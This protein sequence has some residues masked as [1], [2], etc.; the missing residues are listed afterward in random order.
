MKKRIP[1]LVDQVEFAATSNK[2]IPFVICADVSS[3]MA[4]CAQD[5]DGESIPKIEGLRRGVQDGVAYL[6]SMPD[7]RNAVRLGFCTFGGKVTWTPFAALD[8][9]VVP[10]FQA[11][12]YTPMKEALRTVGDE[13]LDF[14]MDMNAIGRPISTATILVVSDGA[15]TTGNPTA[16]IE[17]LLEWSRRKKVHLIAGGVVE[18]DRQN[19]EQLGFPLTA[20]VAALSWKGLIDAGTVS[21]ISIAAG[22]R[23]VSINLCGAPQP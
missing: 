9:V 18:A 3:S 10:D 23:P 22:Q 21:V 4:A 11:T 19:L 14:A 16:E 20:S 2:I 17:R 5:G 1:S 15:P 12:G 7:L 13:F 6:R 8:Q